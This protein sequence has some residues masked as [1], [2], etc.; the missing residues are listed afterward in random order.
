MACVA[1]FVCDAEYGWYP[2]QCVPQDCVS[3]NDVFG[4]CDMYR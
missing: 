1:D 2:G 3:M 4:V